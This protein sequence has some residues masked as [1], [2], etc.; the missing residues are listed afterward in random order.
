MLLRLLVQ[1]RSGQMSLFQ[2]MNFRAGPSLKAK[3]EENGPRDSTCLDKFN[4]VKA[5]AKELGLVLGSVSP[6]P[7]N[8]ATLWQ[9]AVCLCQDALHQTLGCSS[10]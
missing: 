4:S 1:S 10:P 5:S 9:F 2:E 7:A 8:T 3:L 6:A